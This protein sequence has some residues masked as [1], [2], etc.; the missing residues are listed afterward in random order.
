MV[1]VEDRASPASSEPALFVFGN[2]SIGLRDAEGFNAGGIIHST[3]GE[4]SRTAV[5]DERTDAKAR[6]SIVYRDRLSAST[7]V[8]E[9]LIQGRPAEVSETRTGR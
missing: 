5:R 6:S 2:R 3:G 1:F 9:D 4:P 7:E 8:D